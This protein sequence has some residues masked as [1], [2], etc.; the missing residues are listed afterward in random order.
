M[1]QLQ[2]CV[3][4]DYV[5]DSCWCIGF[6]SVVMYM[7][8][9]EDYVIHAYRSGV[10]NKLNCRV[11]LMCSYDSNIVMSPSTTTISFPS[12]SQ[13]LKVEEWSIQVTGAID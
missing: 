10:Y 12:L 4:W 1:T 13:L 6:D 11:H 8:I 7:L 2:G 3:A 5:D 9:Q